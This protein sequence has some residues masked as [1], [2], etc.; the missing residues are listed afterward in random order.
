[1]SEQGVTFDEIIESIIARLRGLQLSDPI[2]IDLKNIDPEVGALDVER[3]ITDPEGTEG[4]A[5]RTL[6]LVL[7]P[8]EV[9]WVT[10]DE[11]DVEDFAGSVRTSNPAQT[12]VE[13]AAAF[14]TNQLFADE[15]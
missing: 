1:M 8:T 2:Q 6:H 9:M 14:G 3:T 15:I 7:R 10:S 5:L 11:D 12:F 13:L 4:L